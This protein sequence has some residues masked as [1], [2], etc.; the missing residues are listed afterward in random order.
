MADAG[1][2]ALVSWS[3]RPRRPRRRPRGARAPGL[4][5][6]EVWV[7]T[8]LEECERRD[9]KGLYAKARAG[10]LPDFT[11]IGQPYEEPSAPDLEV[12]LGEPL[13][14]GG[15][16]ASLAAPSAQPGPHDRV[17]EPE[18][19]ADHRRLLGVPVQPPRRR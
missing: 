3:R 10:E 11:G 17:G 8:P 4:R 16:S 12:P 14:G 6:L 5:F 7:S 1:V 13:D 9:T 18:A 15:A 2:V 19:V